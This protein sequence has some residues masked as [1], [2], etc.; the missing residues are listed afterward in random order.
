MKKLVRS[1]LRSVVAIS[2]IENVES[3][4]KFEEFLRTVVKVGELAEKYEQ[5]RA[6][7]QPE[8]S[9]DPMDTGN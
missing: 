3:C 6:Q 7:E 1:A 4:L 2:K 8:T 5:I 9:T